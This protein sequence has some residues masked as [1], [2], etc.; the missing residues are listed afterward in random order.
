MNFT[1]QL[2]AL[3]TIHRKETT[4]IFRIWMQTLLPAVITQT[5]YFVVFGTF[6]GSQVRDI[7]GIS[8]MAF[9][10][11]GLVMMTIIT[12]SFMNTVSSFFG[13]KFQHSVEELLVSPTPNWIIMTGYVSGGITRGLI[14]GFLVFVISIFFTHP[15]IFSLFII[16]LFAILVST[17]FSLAGFLN[18]LF[19]K[20]FDDISIFPT[21]VLTPLIYLGGVFYSIKNLPEFWQ[22]FSKFNPILY[23]VDGFRYGFFG[24]SDV[25]IWISI[26]MLIIFIVTIAGINLYILKKGYG[27]RT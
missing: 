12:N 13:T 15:Q 9:I 24:I 7:E 14:V 10:V 2:T 4:R 16:F 27:M 23:M 26:A 25:N 8:Y 17:F 6:I 1:E 5:L 18:A 3:G 20:K 11:P 19:A 22:T 21:F